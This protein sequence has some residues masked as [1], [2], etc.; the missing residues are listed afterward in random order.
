MNKTFRLIWNTAFARW[1]VTSEL[2]RARGKRSS[3]AAVKTIAAAT[4]LTAGAV[5]AQLPTGSQVIAGEGGI[6]Q[7]GN[8]LIIEQQ[9]HRLAIEGTSFSIGRDNTVQFIQPDR[10]ASALYRVMGSDVSRIQ[11]S[12]IANGQVFLINPNGILFTDTAHVDVG[13]LIASTLDVD[14]E[15][16]MN[17]DLK[18]EFS[19]SSS[20]AVINQGRI[21][22]DQGTVAMIAARI[23]NTGSIETPR[24]STL[25]GA[26][27][28]V[29]LDLGGSV[30]I[31][32]EEGA[33]DALIEQGGAIS[34][35]GGL[36]YL[37]ASAANQLVT[38]VINHTG[39]TQAQSMANGQNGEIIL[40]GDMPGSRVEVAGALDVSAPN[41]GN[42]G[43]IAIE[44]DH[45]HLAETANIDARGTTGGGNI[46]V[47]GDWQGGANPDY[48]VFNDPNA[49]GE[50]LQVSMAPGATIDAS[51]TDQGDGGTIVLWSDITLKGA[52]TDVKGTLLARGGPNGGDG[53][54]I[55]TSGNILITEG[56]RVRADAPGGGRGGLWF[57]DPEYSLITQGTADGFADTLNTGTNVT[58][59]VSGDL[60]WD[61]GVTL[62]K[63]E[64]GDAT[65]TLTTTDA[66]DI[67][68][69][70]NARIE[71]TSGTLDV[72]LNAD[73]RIEIA[74]SASFITNG[75][76]TRF[77]ASGNEK[78]EI[79]PEPE[80]Q[81]IELEIEP[82][83][84]TQTET[85]D[86]TLAETEAVVAPRPTVR[87][88]G[89]VDASSSDT[90]GSVEITGQEIVL[91]TGA[92]LLAS[93]DQAGGRIALDA[94]EGGQISVDAK[95]DVSSA[96]GE[97]G[98]VIIEA[99]EITLKENT[100]VDATG[101]DGG[102]DILV[103]GDWQ[104]GANE[105]RRVFDDPNAIKQAATVTMQAGASIDA[106]AIDNGDGGTIVLWS[107]INQ[108][109]ATTEVA[110]SL[111]ARG[112]QNGGDGGQI[113]TSGAALR[114]NDV[115][116]DTRAPQ[117]QT[118]TWLLDPTDIFIVKGN[119][120][121]FSGDPSTT[122][123]SNV[124]ADT[125][126][127][128]L[129]STNV[130]VETAADG[131]SG[132]G[133]IFVNDT[134]TWS[135]GNT[136]TLNA[137]RNIEINS[138]IDASQGDG[139]KL[140]LEYGQGSA[141]GTIDGQQAYYLINA[142]VSLQ[143]SGE[144]NGNNVSPTNFTTQLGA[145]GTA[146]HFTTITNTE[147]ADLNNQLESNLNGNFA[148]STNITLTG[149]VNWTPV[150]PYTG[151]F[152]G[153]GHTIFNLSI[154]KA[155]VP[156]VGFF[157]VLA[158]AT[159]QNLNI[160]NADV[161][162]STGV[163]VFVGRTTGNT[164]ITN[165]HV[166]GKVEAKETGASDAGGF[167]GF[168]TPLTISFSSAAVD[169]TAAGRNV[170]GFVG[171][172]NGGSYQYILATGNATST[173]RGQVG[174][175]GGL[176]RADVSDSFA[177][178]NA[179]QAG[180]FNQGV[181]GFI[182][183]LSSGNISRNY[184]VGEA[185]GGDSNQGGFIGNLSGSGVTL[186]NN[187]WDTENSNLD[188]AAGS[189]APTGVTGL[190][191][192][193]MKTAEMKDTSESTSWDF[194]TDP[195]S[196]VLSSDLTYGGYPTLRYTG[197]FAE[198][199]TSNEI[200]SLSNL[201][202]LLEDDTRWSGSYTLTN[203]INAVFTAGWD[204]NKGWTPLGN[205]TTKFTGSFDGL[206]HTISNLTINRGATDN[207]GLFGFTAGASTSDRVTI[208]NLG[209]LGAT[210]TGR[211]Y[212]GALVGHAVNTTI[213]NASASGPVT[214]RAGVGGLIGYAQDVNISQSYAAS[215]VTGTGINVGGLVGRSFGGSGMITES[216]AAG[217]VDGQDR[218]GGLVG[219]LQQSPLSNSYATGNVNG[220]DRVGG[221]V[222]NSHFSDITNSYATGVVTG[223]TDVGGLVGFRTG[224]LTTEITNSYWNSDAL[225]SATNELGTGKALAEMNDFATYTGWDD[226]IWSSF[227]GLGAAV[228]GYEVAQGLP[229]LTNVT[230]KQDRIG[231]FDTLFASGWGGRTAEQQTGAN[232]NAYNITN[233]TQLQ[234][235]N[236]VVGDGFDFELSNNINLNGVSW[237]PIGDNDTRFSGNFDGKNNTL[238]NL[239]INS[240]DE[241]QGLF[242][243]VSDGSIKNLTLD[244]VSM[245]T[246]ED[247]IG[248]LVGR[249]EVADG[250]S[251][252]IE[253]I[254]LND[255]S[256]DSS[257]GKYIGGLIGYIENSDEETAQVSLK[258]IEIN[259]LTI[260]AKDDYVGG[261]VGRIEV[262]SGTDIDISVEN[263]MIRNL[264]IEVL[265]S[266]N[267][268]GGI[269]GRARN[270]GSG[271]ITLRQ[272]AVRNGNIKAVDS[273]RVGGLIGRMHNDT[274]LD[275]RN[276][277][278]GS[279]E[280]GYEVGGLVGRL[281]SNSVLNFGYVH[282]DVIGHTTDE[283][284][285][286]GIITGYTSTNNQI[287]TEIY[288]VGTAKHATE[289]ANAEGYRGGV[290][291]HSASSGDVFEDIY[292][293]VTDDS[294]LPFLGGDGTPTVENVTELTQ[295]QMQGA[296]ARENMVGVADTSRWNFDTN[297]L[298]N[299]D[300]YPIFRWE[301]EQFNIPSQEAFLPDPTPEPTPEP[302]PPVVQPVP[303]SPEPPSLSPEPPSLAPEPQPP[304][305]NRVQ[306]NAIA[307]AQT[308]AQPPS[309]QPASNEAVNRMNPDSLRSSAAATN[310]QTSGD[311]AGGGEA[312]TADISIS[313]G[314]VFVR[315]STLGSD[316]EAGS[317]DEAAGA[318]S[319][320][321]EV[322]TRVSSVDESGFV[323]V[324]AVDG[325]INVAPSADGVADATVIDD[326]DTSQTEEA[327][328]TQEDL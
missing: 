296:Q 143:A 5:H 326:A 67:T 102:G 128:Q 148:L 75:G 248:T 177:L 79:E 173:G 46:L 85:L 151:H 66:G 270:S 210:V 4:L 47:G 114:V 55:E 171:D 174:G 320:S 215:D 229:Y 198:E 70:A 172:A 297:W 140:V 119:S 192:A 158:D 29:V 27:S 302:M 105:E 97:G 262:R 236:L 12:L 179:T 264:D 138:A 287:I 201:V 164:T 235:I 274:L 88:A 184:S 175:F 80:E 153:L 154:D 51:A 231:E 203:S 160:L 123:S 278:I 135:S 60:I 321:P 32:V 96:Q 213:N 300:E 42:G 59:L 86:E 314:L 113:E 286:V 301:A 25:M 68:F 133:D 230:R 104:G 91:D 200:A 56:A 212:S 241:K 111:I 239:S 204:S 185:T 116:I 108:A 156:N 38:T 186:T 149:T 205:S 166:S 131:G 188:N 49:M 14:T 121:S 72:V 268:V 190:K 33:I 249:V 17:G 31:E 45:I 289:D 276:L 137:I 288:A 217:N 285:R 74:S 312:A 327:E 180:E 93:G 136:L 100:E 266:Q 19:G 159:V 275:E 71:S 310:A 57:L 317:A 10:T 6:R 98:Q 130:I 167:V 50:A 43:L 313:G 246:S 280:G 81:G 53:G 220:Q 106:S 1:D 13:A 35:D 238:S 109:E 76:S 281:S 101:K 283:N 176:V 221:L 110:G 73:G 54:M 141:D 58:H 227:E 253:N 20:N 16:F 247:D 120:G 168:A 211:D 178:G 40:K 2:T 252:A 273:R 152:D 233:A 103:G 263:V 216:Y 165:A 41:G 206:G 272:L 277:F 15:A 26:G 232:G 324:F 318:D 144:S 304:A 48:R 207:V 36:V 181:G 44:A 255:S 89:R 298:A 134:I 199:P 142:P 303:P 3:S 189:G 112:G 39:V 170:G 218:V 228:E 11:G 234:N 132:N 61:T 139:G 34:A 30:S 7:D 77:N 322:L 293:H 226:T 8:R 124:G 78:P 328:P 224:E 129:A 191:T 99:E 225:H 23:E 325:G 294:G 259:D 87:F 319:A 265:G 271:E 222:G 84:E 256:I 117:G 82:E 269:A 295:A 183:R 182:G 279:V 309:N 308:A 169:V 193:E 208:S 240:N 65:L 254:T 83:T 244:G 245:Q 22:A 122:N 223:N 157:G 299:V 24:G 195:Q 52:T 282:A 145:D 127:T 162:G 196:W 202:W 126:S 258:R 90:G 115:H 267:Y 315:T 37:T 292:Y 243:V 161:T 260:N 209:L 316:T 92:E 290:I 21:K 95:L 155:S 118:G 94:G 18:L 150:S 146:I 63:T 163:G 305:P 62:T 257:S 250:K 28:K 291:G 107:N 311:G 194:G 64:G 125:L 284:G 261:L 242:G 237:T 307:S 251:V 306:D 197:G 9:S 323:R 214:G 219:E 187:F 69:R 147:G